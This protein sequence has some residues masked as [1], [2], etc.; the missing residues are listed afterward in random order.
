MSRDILRRI[1][2]LRAQINEHNYRYYVLDDPLISDAEYDTLLRELET[3]ENENPKLITPESPT[4]R[5]GAAPLS[6]FEQ[7]SHRQPMLSLANAMSIDELKAFNERVKKA[8]GN[9][10]AIDYVAEPKLDGLGVELVYENGKFILGST[11]GDGYTGENI[12]QNLKTIRAIPLSLRTNKRPVPELLEVR[13]EVF[14]FKD[15]FE[16][17][18]ADRERMGEQLFA[19]PR[20]AAAGSL[21][22]LDPKVT[23]GRPLSIFCYQPGEVSNPTFTTHWEFLDCLRDWGL[24]VNPHIKK[25]K[26]I[27]EAIGYYHELEEKRNSLPY[28]IDGIVLKIDSIV[29]REDLGIRS[30]SPRWAIAGKFKAQ[31]ASTIIRDIEVQV[32]R[33]GA[34]TPVARLEPVQLSGVLVTNATLHNQDEINRKDIRIGDTV[35]VERAGDVIPKVRKVILEY[36]PDGAVPYTMPPICPVCGHEAFKPE[37]EAV[38]RCQN[39]ACPAQ[40]KGRLE[41]F[42]SKGALDID[43]MGTKIIDQLV[44]TGLVKTV[45][46]LFRLDRKTLAGLERLGEKSAENLINAIKSSKETS[47]SRFVHALGIRNVGEHVARILER[48]FRSDLAAFAFSTEQQLTD[49][50]EIGPVVARAITLFWSDPDNRRIVDNCLELGIVLKKP[51]T[52][53]GTVLHGLT[54]VFTGTL[55]TMT[56][57]EA[58]EMVEKLGGRASGSVSKKTDYLVAG[59]GPGSKL[60]KAES[61]GVPVMSEE[62][63][64]KFLAGLS[65]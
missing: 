65:S 22:Q 17:L 6:A 25:I 4:Q 43:G 41:H 7:V 61:L 51:E 5:V 44:E 30:R 1:Q 16:K 2:E 56:R 57:N 26:H 14:L 40:V 55:E 27:D 32:G 15:G 19:N 10:E 53:P 12:T 36:R 24:P 37:D 13:G 64:H 3:L 28:E 50:D 49:I 8:L 63:F 48:A 11:R 21:R 52:E 29:Q 54:F 58:Q 46:D 23:A 60:Q 34:M 35:I 38:L 18:N 9:S 42:V 47:F 45:D 31:Q 59:P 20:N 62:E 33:T 39:L